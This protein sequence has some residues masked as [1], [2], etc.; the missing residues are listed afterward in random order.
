MPCF[1]PLQLSHCLWCPPC[2]CEELIQWHRIS[3]L[4]FRQLLWHFTSAA[5]SQLKAHL[6]WSADTTETPRGNVPDS[7]S[8]EIALSILFLTPFLLIAPP[9][10][11]TVHSTCSSKPMLSLLSTTSCLSITQDFFLFLQIILFS[12]C[13][14]LNLVKGPNKIKQILPHLKSLHA[15]PLFVP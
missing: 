12:P 13:C 8:K 7:S 11:D 6:W 10:K 14:L 5:S 15:F 1:F 3:V 4:L 9:I 2:L